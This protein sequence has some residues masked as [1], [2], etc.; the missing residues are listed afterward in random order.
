MLEV[1]Q[2][3]KLNLIEYV[4]T[5]WNSLYN[6]IERVNLLYEEI[7]AY[8]IRYNGK[9]KKKGNFTQFALSEDD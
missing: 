2:K 7:T 5:R 8:Y 4:D 3:K 6:A 9:S 1:K